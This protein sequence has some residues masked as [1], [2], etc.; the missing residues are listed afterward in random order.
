MKI[1]IIVYSE[2]GHTMQVATLLSKRLI[3]DGHEVSIESVVADSA[4]PNETPRILTAP[5]PSTYE[6]LIFASPVQ[7]F[8]LSPAMR[9]YLTG[10]CNI[11]GKTVLCYLTQ[12]FKKAWLGGNRALRQMK[13]LLSIQGATAGNDGIVHWSAKDRDAQIAALVDALAQSVKGAIR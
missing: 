5:D 12:H 6:G 2:T 7:G 8:S 11:S 10:V 3:E 1:G 4:R 13:E 9:A